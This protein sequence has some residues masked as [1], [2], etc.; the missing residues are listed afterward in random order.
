MAKALQYPE[1]II[2]FEILIN[3]TKIKD[4]IEVK[5]L[6]IEM[7][8]N[9]ITSAMIV[10]HDG[11]ADGSENESYINSEGSDFIPGNEI[12]IRLG[13]NNKKEEVFKGLI[14]SQ[15][16]KVKGYKSQLTVLCKDKAVKMTK[17]RHNA[18]FQNIIDSDALKSI[19][20]NYGL[21]LEIDAT[22][23]SHPVLMQ[24]NCS[25]W[26]YLVIRAEANNMLV[27]TY[28][29]KL[30]VKKIDFNTTPELEINATQFIIDIDLR[31]Q[32]ENLSE[33][34]NMSA[35]NPDTQQEIKSTHLIEDSLNQGNLNAKKLS[36]VLSNT[37]NSYSS[38]SLDTDEM[39]V[40]LASRANSAILEKIQGKITVLGT[41]KVIPG[42]IIKLSGFS[43]RF[44]GNAFISKVTHSLQDGEWLTELYVGRS[45]KLHAA[46]NDVEDLGA[47]GLSPAL[48][49]TQIAT[50]K[51]IHEDPSNKYRI[52]VSLPISNGNGEDLAIWARISVPYASA[53]AGLFFFPEVGDEV[54][55]TFMNNDPRF[56]VIIGSL[57]SAKN[58]PKETPDEKNQF[59]SIYSKSGI[60]ITFDDEDKILTIETP[61]KN[62]IVFD[63]KNKSI[64]I[65][66]VNENTLV[67]DE[68][69]ITMN[70]SKDINLNADGNINLI[71]KSNLAM[72]AMADVTLDGLN[73]KQSAQT[74][75]TAKANA[76]AEL[77]A[78]G[79][80]TVKG[81]MVMIN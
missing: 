51:Q 63:D 12:E 52:L 1:G 70:S 60:H 68:S 38:T 22:T 10:V 6:L 8:V 23:V 31:L 64:N 66:D 29:N 25:D 67:M 44:N 5:E 40:W 4:T 71:A 14:I 55:L 17:G 20:K 30:S 80:T 54:L 77:S 69:G 37:S 27:T 46:L 62:T 57:Y 39:K 73:I 7:E 61:E 65:T 36:A 11:G 75:F 58:K 18:V 2:D 50:V 32:S 3:G 76:S 45:A 53:D 59:K 26:D 9:R 81:A 16:L 34:Y 24:Y 47:S 21:K 13:Y 48:R 43:A 72:K 28:Q 78:S 74:S 49:G 35:W 33:A 79:Q 42:N 56:P 41:T 15:Q 19:V